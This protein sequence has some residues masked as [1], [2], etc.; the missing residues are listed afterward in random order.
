MGLTYGVAKGIANGMA[1][2]DFRMS[3]LPMAGML[4]L[5]LGMAMIVTL[6][7]YRRMSQATIVERL[8]EAE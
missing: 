3:P 5:L 7:S 1:F 6:S 8:R 2:T 4:A